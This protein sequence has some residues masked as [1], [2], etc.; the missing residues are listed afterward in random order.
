MTRP[1]YRF[2]DLSGY[3][4]TGKH[5][6]IDLMR[7]FDGYSVP[8]F[9]FEFALLRVQGGILDLERALCEDWSPIRSDAAIRRFERLVRRFG[10]KNTLISPRSWFEAVGWNYEEYYNRRF[11]DLSRRY[12]EGLVAARWRAPWPYPLADL[13][14][15]ELFSRKLRQK[16]RQP[17]AMDFE[18]HLA[19][20]ANFVEAT[21][22]YLE[23]LLSSNVPPG[24][25]TIVMHNAFE[26]YQPDRSLK[27][28]R[29]AKAIV[30]DRDPRDNYVQGLWY[31]PVATGV[32]EFI[33][34]YRIQRE[35]THYEPNP[36]VLRL[37]FE[38]LVLD[39]PNALGRILG[40]LGESPE[41]HVR[42]RQH[43]DPDVSK[44]NVGIWRAYPKQD[45]IRRIAE[46]LAD[47]CD[48]R[49]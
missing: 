6:V 9:Q 8:H 43:F 31:A 32:R 19:R 45:E 39:Y 22:D 34:R 1:V 29:S 46:E 42:P 24:T 28:F 12:V 25:R 49:L 20:P 41:H 27:F 23:A 16:L 30:V 10:T 26:P 40:H 5:A 15:G 35:A 4:F 36:D 33:L 47:F 11:F 2:L 14:A 44:K 38:D 18:Y 13:S 21:R 7:E 48:P 37:R 3:A 17:H